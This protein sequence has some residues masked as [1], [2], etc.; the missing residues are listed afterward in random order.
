MNKN[1][2]TSNISRLDLSDHMALFHVILFSPE[3]WQAVFYRY[4]GQEA[5]LYAHISGQP[6]GPT[7]GHPGAFAKAALT[8]AC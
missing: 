8:N 4:P 5:E 7:P 1:D 3:F 2:S 6:G